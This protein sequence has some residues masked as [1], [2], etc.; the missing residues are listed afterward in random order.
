MLDKL[1]W[2]ADSGAEVALLF[3]I[4]RK[5]RWR[6]FP[7]FTILTAFPLLSSMI[8]LPMQLLHAERWYDYVYWAYSGLNVLIQFLVVAELARIVLRP[9]GTWVRDSRRQFII[10]ALAGSLAAFAFA[11]LVAPPTSGPLLGL[12]L[13]G[14]LFTSLVTCELLICILLASNKLGLAWK[15]HVMAIS[16]GLTVWALLAIVTDS[17]HSYYGPRHFYWAAEY[18]KELAELGALGYWSV[19]LWHEE[20]ARQPIS[21]ELLKYIVALHHRV[22][23]DL[24]EAG[25]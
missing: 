6:E 23:Y 17:I 19:Q 25:H 5:G 18:F 14:E 12:E 1:F 9:T 20:P 16:V 3:V 10:G 22:H 24:G 13:R 21:P 11:Y 4:L 7:A 8:L 15:N 2:L